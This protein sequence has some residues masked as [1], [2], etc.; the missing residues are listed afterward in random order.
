MYKKKRI[1]FIDDLLES[2]KL[3]IYDNDT[4]PGDLEGNA[5]LEFSNKKIS[6]SNKIFFRENCFF[7]DENSKMKTKLNNF[8]KKDFFV[9]RKSRRKEL[10][11][12]F[13]DIYKSDKIY[14]ENVNGTKSKEDDSFHE[15]ESKL[16]KESKICLKNFLNLSKK[17]PSILK[18]TDVIS[19]S[20][21]YMVEVRAVFL[22]IGEI[23]TLNEKF[24]AEAFVEAKWTDPGLDPKTK[25]DPNTHWNPGLFIFNS[26]GELKQQVWY[27]QYSINE[28]QDE[29]ME[30]NRLNEKDKCVI[31]Y[32][33]NKNRFLD[34]NKIPESNY[35]NFCRSG[36]VL[37]E[38]RRVTGSFWKMLNLKNF[39]A[40]VQ[41][42]TITITTPKQ[43]NEVELIHCKD[44]CSSV[45]IKCF[46]DT[47]E[48]R[49]YK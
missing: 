15:I 27:S 39:P 30:N 44:K 37:V 45:N 6:K 12:A 31:E 43:T 46:I 4:T 3:S 20:I 42:L 5:G 25:Y 34:E 36:S 7:S 14:D 33:I 23:D 32:E 10:T 8:R 11:T 28:Y 13:S 2:K 1:Q 17:R 26:L 38:R 19:D 29:E 18:K 16:D 21:K 35:E 49:L 40:D 41:D 9:S 24:Y 47:Q 22:K 48:W